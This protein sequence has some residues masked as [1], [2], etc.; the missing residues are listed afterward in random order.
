MT[1]VHFAASLAARAV[2]E[3]HHPASFGRQR[4]A[5]GSDVSHPTSAAIGRL[6]ACPDVF[7]GQATK[8]DDAHVERTY[9][10][11][12]GEHLEE[13]SDG[14]MRQDM[15][16]GGKSAAI[17]TNTPNVPQVLALPRNGTRRQPLAATGESTPGRLSTQLIRSRLLFA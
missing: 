10:N 4:I 5:A 1:S 3:R 8:A 16:K 13:Q 17:C 9:D 7:G 12:K 11:K 6:P 2:V 15:A 14:D